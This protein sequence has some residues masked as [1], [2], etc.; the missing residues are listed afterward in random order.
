MFKTPGGAGTHTARRSPSPSGRNPGNLTSLGGT[1]KLHQRAAAGRRFLGYFVG[2]GR[3]GTILPSNAFTTL[4]IV[5]VYPLQL[6]VPPLRLRLLMEH[7]IKG[8]QSFHVSMRYL[9]AWN[10]VISTKCVHG[11]LVHPSSPPPPGHRRSGS[12]IVEVLRLPL[13]KT[14]NLALALEPTL[15]S[16]PPS[17]P[18]EEDRRQQLPQN[19]PAKCMGS[20]ER[21]SGGP[22]LLPAAAAGQ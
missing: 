5:L 3:A 11:I 18:I 9:E 22:P 4:Y 8:L 20:N 13:R 10:E 1:G 19:P 2:R 12:T 14:S 7:A 15:T 17:S 21:V 6:R 16:G